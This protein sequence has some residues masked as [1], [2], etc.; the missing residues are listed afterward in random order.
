MLLAKK[1]LCFLFRILM[2]KTSVTVMRRLT[3]PEVVSALGF[4]ADRCRTHTRA[5][6]I[7]CDRQAKGLIRTARGCV[8]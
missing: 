3:Y 1:Q 5:L 7:L 6:L 2:E 4:R 8:L